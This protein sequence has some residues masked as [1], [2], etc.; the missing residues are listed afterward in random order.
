MGD[1]GDGLELFL[2]S[3]SRPGRAHKEQHHPRLSREAVPDEYLLQGR[4]IGRSLPP[5][6]AFPQALTHRTIS[7]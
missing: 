4:A 3:T 1:I 7:D 6:A 2:P 5:A